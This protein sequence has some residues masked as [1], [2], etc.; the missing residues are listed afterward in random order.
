MAPVT[1]LTATGLENGGGLGNR[2]EARESN[3]GDRPKK[4]NYN[5]NFS[6]IDNKKP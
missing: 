1:V 6:N 4:S 5:R 2:I 3:A